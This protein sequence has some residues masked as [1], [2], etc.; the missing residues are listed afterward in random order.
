MSD[1]LD[2]ASL[3]ALWR[4]LRAATPVETA[5]ACVAAA[6]LFAVYTALSR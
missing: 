2:A 3:A 4:S 5:V 1:L 6:A